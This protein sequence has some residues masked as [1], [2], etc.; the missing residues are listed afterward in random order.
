MRSLEFGE[1]E[2]FVHRPF[3]EARAAFHGLDMLQEI[4]FAKDSA[5][6]Y[7]SRP[8]AHM[9]C[10][11]SCSFECI[12]NGSLIVDDFPLVKTPTQPL[13][14]LQMGEEGQLSA[15]RKSKPEG[16]GKG[17]GFTHSANQVLFM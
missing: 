1:I 12:L 5:G 15:S 17:K 13:L 8:A 14:V 3:V 10:F 2:V 6:E 7:K 4:G 16:C 9:D 11:R